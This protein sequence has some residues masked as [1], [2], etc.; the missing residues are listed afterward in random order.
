LA[1]K[2]AEVPKREATHQ[3]PQSKG[4]PLMKNNWQLVLIKQQK[5]KEQRKHQA[6]LAMAMR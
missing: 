4:A 3:Y 1:R 5:E 6:K 2:L